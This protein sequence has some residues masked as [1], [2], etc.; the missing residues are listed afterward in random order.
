[1]SAVMVDYGNQEAAMRAYLAEGEQRAFAL[2]NRGPIRFTAEGKVHPDILAA[3]WRCGLSL[4]HISEP[5]RPY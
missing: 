1:M 5:T 3:Y 2:G 4:I